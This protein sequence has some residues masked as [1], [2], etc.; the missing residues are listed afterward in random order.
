MVHRSEAGDGL[1]WTGGFTAHLRRQRVAHGVGVADGVG[2]VA[3]LAAVELLDG[4]VGL[5]VLGHCA[6]GAGDE[7]VVV[8]GSEVLFEGEGRR[9]DDREF[10]NFFDV[11]SSI[12]TEQHIHCHLFVNSGT[13]YEYDSI[14]RLRGPSE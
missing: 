4:V 6:E 5:G 7:V 13:E 2:E 14:G 1:N 9:R 11:V 12:A 3:L 10:V 8:G